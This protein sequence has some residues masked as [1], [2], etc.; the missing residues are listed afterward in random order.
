M[1]VATCI[2][3]YHRNRPFDVAQVLP[4]KRPVGLAN[5]DCVGDEA[6]LLDC[7]SEPS[8][9]A[10]CGVSGTM[11]TESILLACSTTDPSAPADPPGLPSVTQSTRSA[12][13]RPV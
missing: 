3:P 7:A 4:K 12:S 10:D 8:R 11:A 5:V 1:T 13:D 2:V 9:V 6:S